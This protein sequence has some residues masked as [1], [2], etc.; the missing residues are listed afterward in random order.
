[1]GQPDCGPRARAWPPPASA[2]RDARTVALPWEFL[3]LR[4]PW[5]DADSELYFLALQPDISIVRH[6]TLGHRGAIIGA[7]A[8]YRL[9]AAQASPSDQP[10]LALAAERKAIEAV[11]GKLPQAGLLQPVWIEKT[12]RRT[13][14]EALRT[15][16]DILHFSGHGRAAAASGQILLERAGGGSDPYGAT[17]LASLVQ[18]SPLRLAILNVCETGDRSGANPWSGVA[19]ALVRAGVA[20]VVASQYPILDASATPLAEEIYL[21]VLQGL[22]IDEAVSNARRAIYQEAGVQTPDWAAPVLYLRDEE[23]LIFPPSPR[24]A[25]GQPAGPRS[26]RQRRCGSQVAHLRAS[27]RLARIAPCSAAD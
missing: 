17:S 26:A 7:A 4:P 2:V 6:E 14:R 25:T 9:V 20:A 27:S 23:G 19:S 1:M 22:T 5:D 8:S 15:P 13:L 18:A 11:I 24:P 16:A 3:Y 12:T 21:G 10:A